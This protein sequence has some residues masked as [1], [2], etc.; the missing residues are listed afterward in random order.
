MKTAKTYIS[1]IRIATLSETPNP[2]I[3]LVKLIQ[4]DAIMW[5]FKNTTEDFNMESLEGEDITNDQIYER[6]IK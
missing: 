3:E 4:K 2:L 6:S 5:A 1:A